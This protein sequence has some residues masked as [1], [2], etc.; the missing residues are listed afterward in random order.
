M[1]SNIG[2]GRGTRQEIFNDGTGKVLKLLKKRGAAEAKIEA[3]KAEL[4]NKQ[5]KRKVMAMDETF[6]KSKAEHLEEEFKKQTVGLQTAE[7]FKEKREN[8]NELIR[9]AEAGELVQEK[10]TKAKIVQKKKT[11]NLSF[12]GDSDDSDDADDDPFKSSSSSSKRQAGGARGSVEVK[13]KK[14]P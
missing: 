5:K 11:Q 3:A 8:I 12:A 13:K 10:K 9:K 1:A 4:E 2:D 14:N 7:E 6:A